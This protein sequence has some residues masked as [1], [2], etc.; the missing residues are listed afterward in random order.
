MAPSAHPAT[1][2]TPCSPKMPPPSPRFRHT[3]Y[4]SPTGL[5][6]L[7]ISNVSEGLLPLNVGDGPAIPIITPASPPLFSSNVYPALAPTPL[8]QT[9]H[10]S[11][12]KSAMG[13]PGMSRTNSTG[14]DGTGRDGDHLAPPPTSGTGGIT[15]HLSDTPVATA[16]NSPRM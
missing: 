8:K 12:A 6:S 5:S 13:A 7:S 14:R 15:N 10:S 9:Q 16:P 11:I 4:H 1:Q 2:T 3:P